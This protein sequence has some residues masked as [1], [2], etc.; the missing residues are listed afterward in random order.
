MRLLIAFFALLFVT[1][2]STVNIQDY[3]NTLP[4]L[5]VEDISK[6]KQKLGAYS[7]TALVRFVVV[8]RLISLEHGIKRTL[9]LNLLSISSMMM[10]KLNSVFG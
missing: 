3:Q 5:K 2:C 7:K 6:V 1:G 4:A 8:L 10:G 9:N